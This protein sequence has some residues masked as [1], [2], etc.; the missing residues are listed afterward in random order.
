MKKGCIFLVLLLLLPTYGTS[1]QPAW[2]SPQAVAR[3]L[4]TMENVSG[5]INAVPSLLDGFSLATP[6]NVT[7]ELVVATGKVD[8]LYR[9]D[10]P[11]LE[12]A[13]LEFYHLHNFTVSQQDTD[14]FFSQIAPLPD[15]FSQSIALLV[16]ALN[17]ASRSCTFAF[18]N[19]TAD[20]RQFLRQ[21]NQ[22]DT[23]VTD[24][25][26]YALS[27]RIKIFPNLDLFASN[28]DKLSLLVQKIDR[29]ALVDG[30]LGLLSAVR[31][32]LP[33][34]EKYAAR[35]NQ[36]MVL[37]DP[38]GHIRV[39]GSDNTTH[40]GTCSL[41][42]DLGG[43]D[44]ITVRHPEEAAALVLNVAGN[45]RYQGQ[46]AKSFAGISMLI[47]VRGNDFYTANNWSQSYACAGLTAL[48]D[49]RGDDVYAGGSHVQAAARAGGLAV[50]A[51]VRGNDTYHAY[52]H[53][54]A[55]A[56][57]N[58]LALLVDGTGNDVYTAEGYAQGYGSSGGLGLLVDVLGNDIY[59]ARFYAQG[60]G[61]G[62]ANGLKKLGTGVLLDGAGDDTY[63]ADRF[64]QGYGKIVGVGVMADLLGN[65]RYAARAS[66][67]ASSELFGVACLL[68]LFGNNTY[69]RSLHSGG[70]EGTWGTALLV[71]G[72]GSAFNQKLWD[73]LQSLAEYDVAPFSLLFGLIGG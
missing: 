62:W 48:V 22:S 2:S 60:A 1:Q 70:Y 65:D 29:A 30:G 39:G 4:P 57:G 66:S 9:E 32:A 3:E 59:D 16:Y 42:I 18:R 38:S 46:M 73:L 35:F 54:Q 56:N 27:E 6:R 26:R 71:D 28:T 14:L 43:D 17:D 50:L 31:V 45:D 53:A 10:P 40:V 52:S 36:S 34:L 44:L 20:E 58:S 47:D 68:D 33:V 51:D 55:C 49:M 12:E 15:E 19:L 67:Q 21:H 7:M 25:L 23:N 72:M 5:F 64:S 37:E 11:W 69:Q 24:V 8:M 61:Q 13:V 41:L 63:T